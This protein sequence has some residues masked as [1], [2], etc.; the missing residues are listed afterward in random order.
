[1]P[2]RRARAKRRFLA[3]PWLPIVAYLAIVAWLALAT[4]GVAPRALVH[5]LPAWLVLTWSACIAVGGTLAFI[6]PL[7]EGTL[8]ETAG[9]VMLLWGACMY[10]VV[11]TVSLWPDSLTTVLVSVAIATMCYV[12]LRVLSVARKAQRVARRIRD[13]G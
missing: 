6:G 8:L 13:A 3:A 5:T 11:L 10:G 7:V 12:R 9:L 4:G 1:M 2:T